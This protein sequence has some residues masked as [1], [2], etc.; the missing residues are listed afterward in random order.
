MSKR[1]R[2]KER[3]PQPKKV[4]LP[5]PGAHLNVTIDGFDDEGRGRATV[6]IDDVDVDVA[7]RGAFPGDVVV[8]KVERVFKGRQ[9]LVGRLVEL[10]HG[11]EVRVEGICPHPSPCPGCA[12]GDVDVGFA[13]EAKAERLRRALVDADLDPLLAHVD[14]V[15]SDG[16]WHTR[17]KVR[18]M[19]SGRPGRL[20]LGLFA[21]YSHHVVSAHQC[22][23]ARP[24]VVEAADALLQRLHDTYVGGADSDGEL[25]SVLLREMEPDDDD[26]PQ[27][28][29]LLQT[30]RPLR[31]EVFDVIASLVDDGVLQSVAERVR[32]V[33]DD[34]SANS[35]LA[36]DVLRRRGPAVAV[37]L[38]GGPEVDPDGFCQAHPELASW[39]YDAA[40]S[41]LIDDVK[42]GWMVD[43]YAGTGG[44]T[45]ALLDAAD[46]HAADVQVVGVEV[47][48]SCA[49]PLA[50]SG[51]EVMARTMEDALDALEQRAQH[52]RPVGM[53]LDPPRKGLRDAGPRLAAL[54]T[55][56]VVL[57]S[58][59]P[60]AMAKDLRVFVDAGYVVER[61]TPVDLFPTSMSVEAMSV[62]RW[63]ASR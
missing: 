15:V 6:T 51:A 5:P 44:F 40:A 1:R 14:D 41:V 46:A 22:A 7:V 52:S 19:A 39:M 58:C 2:Q 63:P 11:G 8:A 33:D 16:W 50:E 57:V 34:A 42:A 13:H 20:R 3:P 32:R 10:E 28:A 35:V 31:G 17:Q 9:L 38:G 23:A 60:T 62:L 49:T 56:T 55:P 48:P 24:A 26:I 45:R 37:P 4:S 36:G 54:Q 53:V 12:L 30:V 25:Q 27:V 47:T 18:L 21:P 61:I 43:G 29:C 59:D